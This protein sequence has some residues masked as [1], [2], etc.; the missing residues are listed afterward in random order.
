MVNQL[1]FKIIYQ[2]FHSHSATE[3][4]LSY[5]LKNQDL[6]TPTKTAVVT[7]DGFGIKLSDPNAVTM[8]PLLTVVTATA[9]K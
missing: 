5:P 4:V 3:Q 7:L 8:V 9:N 6:L 2:Y 1:Y